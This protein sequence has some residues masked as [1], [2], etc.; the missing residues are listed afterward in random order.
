M[1]SGVTLRPSFLASSAMYSTACCVITS[2]LAT[3][4]SVGLLSLAGGRLKTPIGMPALLASPTIVT[5]LSPSCGM[6]MMPST[7]WAMQSLTCSSCLLASSLAL[8][9]ITFDAQAVQRLDDGLV[10]GDPE[11]SLQVL[12]GKADTSSGRRW[13]RASA[14]EQRPLRLLWPLPRPRCRG[15]G[16]A[17]PPP[18]AA[19]AESSM[20]STTT[21][22]NTAC[23]RFIV[24]SPIDKPLNVHGANGTPATNCHT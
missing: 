10:P 15:A 16:A 6:M 22:A 9:S 7:P 8:R 14:P 17:G 5:A 20:L 4:T 3:I 1:I 21:I 23:S 18:G 11:L 2:L 12:V 19:H 13:Q 24:S